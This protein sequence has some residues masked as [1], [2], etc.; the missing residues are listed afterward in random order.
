[1][2]LFTSQREKQLWLYVLIV[3][4]AITTTLVF[5][6]GFTI[7]IVNQNIQ[8]IIFWIAFILIGLSTIIHGL[9]SKPHKVEIV[10][11]FGILAV[12]LLLFLR[13]GHP[14]RTHLMEYSI[15]AIFIH[16]ALI[17]RKGLRNK[18]VITGLFAFLT[19]FSI[20]VIDELIQLFLPSRVFDP[21]DILFNSLAAF[22]TISTSLIL[23]WIKN[24]VK[25]ISKS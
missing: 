19:T 2:P 20:G 7:I 24:M 4:F 23:F 1:M 25:K 12:Y 11:W 13:V 17:E 15:L 18:M 21:I 5:A 9:K 22:M 3:L 14:E 10:V 16:K 6:R 8:A